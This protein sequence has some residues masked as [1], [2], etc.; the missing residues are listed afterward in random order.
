MNKTINKKRLATA[1]LTLSLLACYPAIAANKS[2]HIEKRS[3]V[4]VTSENFSVISDEGQ[5]VATELATQLEMFRK[6][7]ALFSRH[8]LPSQ[9]R[10]VKVFSVDYSKAYEVLAGGPSSFS[11]WFVDRRAGNYAIMRARKL[12]S[13][14]TRHQSSIALL[15][16][17]YTHY[18][19]ANMA[20]VDLPFWYSEGLADY[21][22]TIRFEDG[23]KIV[24]GLPIE[25]HQRSIRYGTWV[26]MKTLLNGTRGNLSY[27]QYF[28][29]YPQGWLMVHYFQADAERH[30]QMSKYFELLDSGVSVDAAVEQAFEKT[31]LELDRALKAY[32][33]T[34]RL[35]YS[36]ITLDKA[37]DVGDIKVETM[38]TSTVLFE[39]GE[40]LLNGGAEIVKGESRT[41]KLLEYDQKREANARQLFERAIELESG[42][43]GALA[44]LAKIQLATSPIEAAKTI[45]EIKLDAHLLPWIS[46]VSGQINT[47]L[48]VEATT[49]QQRKQY[50]SLA[51][52]DYN[53][54]IKQD[55]HNVGAI[56]GAAGLYSQEAQ[57][58]KAADLLEV[59]LSIA[60]SNSSLRKDLIRAYFQTGRS[61]D[62]EAEVEI[63]KR[64][65]HHSSKSLEAFEK[66]VED[67]KSMN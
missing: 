7:F 63:I 19:A 9:M 28:R 65:A 52:A 38:P 18:L 10:P 16:H 50:R 12:E 43:S 25:Y 61:A 40:F 45:A 39:V 62:A 5:E 66:W 60:P 27:D 20:A 57:W 53:R 1:L 2:N 47:R 36:L 67:I 49:E 31:Y 21:L 17:E 33:K 24:Y 35:P 42:H 13:K 29:I 37:W 44:G 15:F 32:A 41:K 3:W 46:T 64:D 6:T 48:M 59:A 4:R 55:P 23:N 58:G 56:A 30:K 22:S 26:P 54:A 11:G 14:A 34:R 8:P 51:V